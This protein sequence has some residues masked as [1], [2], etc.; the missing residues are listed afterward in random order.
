MVKNRRGRGEKLS[1]YWNEGNHGA[2]ELMEEF[3]KN[4]E[5]DVWFRCNGLWILLYIA[6]LLT[7]IDPSWSLKSIVKRL[8]TGKFLKLRKSRFE[9]RLIWSKI[10]FRDK[11]GTYSLFSRIRNSRT[12]GHRNVSRPI[13]NAHMFSYLDMDIPG[14]LCLAEF[15][16]DYHPWKLVHLVL[17]CSFKTKDN[18]YQTWATDT[19]SKLD[20]HDC[21]NMNNDC[22]MR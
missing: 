10:G 13:F 5:D 2:R 15:G 1:S 7:P 17:I 12:A 14:R 11:V 20:V 19:G 9:N 22:I 3:W 21:I 8:Y 6:F 18:L 4:I 16:W